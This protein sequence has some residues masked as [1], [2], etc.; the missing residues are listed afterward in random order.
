MDVHKVEQRL[1]ISLSSRFIL[2]NLAS[3]PAAGGV[4][5]ELGVV[6]LVLV[7]RGVLL[8]L[9]DLCSNVHVSCIRLS[10]VSAERTLVRTLSSV[11]RFFSASFTA[12]STARSSF[13][14][15]SRVARYPDAR[16]S[17]YAVASLAKSR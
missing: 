17:W 12:R 7:L 14:R 8:A 1:R 11:L 13:V 6:E 9:V 3:E 15:L 2:G 5:G 4:I 16:F 10:A